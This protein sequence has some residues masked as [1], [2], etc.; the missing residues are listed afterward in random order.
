MGVARSCFLKNMLITM[1]HTE[2]KETSTIMSI[3]T[4]ACT[5]C[6]STDHNEMHLVNAVNFYSVKYKPQ[7]DTH[8]YM[9]LQ[10]PCDGKVNFPTVGTTATVVES[11]TVVLWI[12]ET[13]PLHY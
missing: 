3:L 4:E 5:Y 10:V 1:M 2:N 12:N 7:L 8:T 13:K 11:G 9:R 6:Y